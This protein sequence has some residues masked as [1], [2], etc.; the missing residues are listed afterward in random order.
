[1]RRRPIDSAARVLT[2]AVGLWIGCSA[3]PSAPSAVQAAEPSG[4]KAKAKDKAKEKSMLKSDADF[5]GAYKSYLEKSGKR[6]QP[7]VEDTYLR[8][9]EWRFFSLEGGPNKNEEVAVS[10]SGE[11]IDS[12]GAQP[13]WYAFLTQTGITA[14]DLAKRY[15]W[16]QR[17]SRIGAIEP[18]MINFR[19]ARVAPLVEKPTVTQHGDTVTLRFWA[20]FPPSTE[21]P[22]RVTVTAKKGAAM[23]S[24][25][26]GWQQVAGVAPAT[27][28]GR[29]EGLLP[30]M[31][32]KH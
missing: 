30:P 9:G 13:G 12:T 1:M 16:L 5:N 11:V 6:T 21:D 14:G 26:A 23:H 10:A 25:S 4:V 28:P 32:P 18:G 2:V 7:I 20:V 24:E 22:S 19:D 31:F 3:S 17:G 27:Q 8:T 29:Q 15:C